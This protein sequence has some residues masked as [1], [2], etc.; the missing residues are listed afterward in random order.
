MSQW[1]SWGALDDTTSFWVSFRGVLKAPVPDFPPKSPKTP[2]TRSITL[3]KPPCNTDQKHLKIFE[4]PP[5]TL[6]IFSKITRGSYFFSL[7]MDQFFLRS[8]KL[9]S[10]YESSNLVDLWF[11]VEIA[12]L[13]NVNFHCTTNS[14]FL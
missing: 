1:V 5:K 11:G 9:H 2:L 14:I 13:G 6:E 8:A 7:G 3:L 4:T 10:N 12:T